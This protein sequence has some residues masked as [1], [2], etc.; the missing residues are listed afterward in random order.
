M[1][2]RSVGSAGADMTLNGCQCS[3]E[4]AGTRSLTHC[5]G[6]KALRGRGGRAGGTTLSAL[7]SE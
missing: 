3:R 7:A 1:S 4:M 5:P 6:S 2:R